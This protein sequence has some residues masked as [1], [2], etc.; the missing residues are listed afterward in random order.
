MWPPPDVRVL[1]GP[2][3]GLV[4]EHTA[5]LVAE[6]SCAARVAC[7]FVC[8]LEA[9]EPA[10]G[11]GAP[12]SQEA[13]SELRSALADAKRPAEVLDVVW[14]DVEEG[15][16]VAF[17]T[18][19]LGPGQRVA[20]VFAGVTTTDAAARVARFE[21]PS[22]SSP[23]PCVAASASLEGQWHE[24]AAQARRGAVRAILLCG[25]VAP[26][27]LFADLCDAWRKAAAAEKGEQAG[28]GGMAGVLD[29]VGEEQPLD[30]ATE[31][32]GP[33][34]PRIYLPVPRT[35]SLS[36]QHG[37]QQAFAPLLRRRVRELLGREPV[38]EAMAACP[39]LALLS[40]DALGLDSSVTPPSASHGGRGC[41]AARAGGRPPPPAGAALAPTL[42]AGVPGAAEAEDEADELI[43]SLVAPG[44]GTEREDGSP[45]SEEEGCDS[46]MLGSRTGLARLREL[47]ARGGAAAEAARAREVVAREAT[48]ALRAPMWPASHGP[49]T[50]WPL[51]ALCREVCAAASGPEAGARSSH[52]GI[53]VWA[54]V[55]VF[56]SYFEP[57]WAPMEAATSKEDLATGS[58][59]LLRSRASES[60]LR[61]PVPCTLADSARTPLPQ[62]WPSP[63]ACRAQSTP[64]MGRR[65]ARRTRKAGKPWTT[66]GATIQPSSTPPG[67]MR[68]RRWRTGRRPTLVSGCETR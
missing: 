27:A 9:P 40:P 45:R 43:E 56:G 13:D 8:Q 42:V 7:V 60:L 12:G 58:T 63:Q 37:L 17:P 36:A 65:S 55:Q 14:A 26:T 62:A 18:S 34:S 15:Q 44:S 6:F 10:P 20:A 66:R 33:S 4:T 59:G 39:T 11:P 51:V 2:I 3:L 48:E 16:P 49:D 67:G 57:L 41:L 23:Y 25:G 46:A 22:S 50:P 19:A 61:S 52:P 54:I 64:R 28:G 21:T 35:H 5:R 31:V 68:R 30:E 53:G 24:L 47:V 1:V 32:R 29:D 38:R